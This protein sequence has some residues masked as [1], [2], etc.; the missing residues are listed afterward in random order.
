MLIFW[1]AGVDGTASDLL[2]VK[3]N[4]NSLATFLSVCL[5][6]NVRLCVCQCQCQCVSVSS[7]V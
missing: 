4:P 5:S 1:A 7:T 2:L 3:N 6:G